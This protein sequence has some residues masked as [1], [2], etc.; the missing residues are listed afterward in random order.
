MRADSLAALRM[1]EANIWLEAPETGVVSKG[2]KRWR[3]HLEEVFGIFK[4]LWGAT[5]YGVL[6][7]MGQ[8]FRPRIHDMAIMEY[9]V[10]TRI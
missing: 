6:F 10:K 8:N 7:E 4:G 2:L 3:T 1:H 9:L 5:G